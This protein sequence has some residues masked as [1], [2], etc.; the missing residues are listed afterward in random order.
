MLPN[1]CIFNCEVSITFLCINLFQKY[2]SWQYLNIWK[3]LSWKSK[4]LSLV[5][6]QL[7]ALLENY[8]NEIEKD[9][10]HLVYNRI[11]MDWK[12]CTTI[13]EMYNKVCILSM[14]FT[15][16]SIYFKISNHSI[17]FYRHF[18]ILEIHCL[19]TLF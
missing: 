1:N 8:I 11:V 14:N 10:R 5:Q 3:R 13:S 9:I 16:Y 12:D 15:I 18:T 2:P 4:T 7:E 17:I 6:V 19:L